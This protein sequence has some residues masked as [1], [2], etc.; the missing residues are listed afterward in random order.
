[1]KDIDLDAAF[2]SIARSR[3]AVLGD[4]CVDQYLV[5]DPDWKKTSVETG[6]PVRGVVDQRHSPGGAGNVAVNVAT[7]GVAAVHCLGCVGDDP[8][9][10]YLAADLRAAGCDV[11]GMFA[12]KSE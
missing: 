6:K 4:F 1:V 9:G 3:I 12:Q 10:A 8:Y 2:A 7:L 11:T 5:I